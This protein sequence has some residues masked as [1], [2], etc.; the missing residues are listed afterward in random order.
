MN[1]ESLFNEGYSCYEN[2]EFKKAILHYE[3]AL[4]LNPNNCA[5]ILFEIAECKFDLE[6]YEESI[7]YYT[8]AIETDSTAPLIYSEEDYYQSRALAYQFLED[9]DAAYD[10]YSK[11]SEINPHEFSYFEN[12]AHCIYFDELDDSYDLAIKDMDAAIKIRSK[13]KSKD[14]KDYYLFYFRAKLKL[15]N[16]EYEDALMDLNKAF[17]IVKWDPDQLKQKC[18]NAISS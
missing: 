13:N 16:Q 3:K 6:E 7:K 2:K 4:A 12:K 17:E 10:D 9:Y 1:A 14:D 8:K 15:I 11:A 5:D 18:I